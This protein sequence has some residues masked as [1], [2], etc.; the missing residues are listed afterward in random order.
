MLFFRLIYLVFN[1]VYK[2]KNYSTNKV[3]NFK[4][5]EITDRNGKILANSVEVYDFYL[6]P[7][8]IENIKKKNKKINRIIPNA[9]KDEKAMLN[10]LKAKQE[11]V[12]IIKRE[13]HKVADA[14]YIK[15]N[16]AGISPKDIRA[17]VKRK[18]KAGCELK[19]NQS[20]AAVVL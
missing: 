20:P 19:Q 3:Q 11:S 12:Y 5:L 14:A 2:H 6:Q 1:D 18:Q 7:S 9:I 13:N 15:S 17:S 4:R 10:K 8:R 16:L